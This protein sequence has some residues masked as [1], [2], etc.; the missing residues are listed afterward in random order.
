MKQHPAAIDLVG[1]TFYLSE[2]ERRRLLT[3]GIGEGLF[4]AG[5]NHVA[6]DIVASDKEHK[7]IT[8]KPEELLEMKKKET[9][10]SGNQEEDKKEG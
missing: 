1:D 3:S 6:I 5:S 9:G 2:G 4:F 7:L 8:T 10:T